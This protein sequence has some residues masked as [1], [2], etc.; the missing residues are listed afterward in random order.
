MTI[1]DSPERAGGR[2]PGTRSTDTVVG[3]PLEEA[4]R[5]KVNLA[6]G[7][8]ARRGDGYHELDSL[9]VFAELADRLTFEPAEHLMLERG[10][11]FGA[12]LAGEPDDLIL[13][14]ARLLAVH[15]GRPAAARITLD[16]RIPVA[17][18]LGGGSADAAATLRGL[19]RL[20]RLDLS[21]AELAPLARE[22]GADVPVCLH[23]R[24]ARMRGIGERLEA[25]VGLPP[26]PL[27]LVNPGKAV[28]T[29]AVFEALGLVA[30]AP[31]RPAL[32]PFEGGDLIDWLRGWGNHLEAP[33]RARVPAIGEVLTILAAAPGCRLARMSGSGA[34]CF[35]VFADAAARDRAARALRRDFPHWWV[36]ATVAGSGP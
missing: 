12:A 20:W 4:A 23:G 13:R 33:A 15:A 25:L 8:L 19:N 24:P 32:P 7:V 18:G 26:L 30:G 17:A 22:L 31:P 36:E 1:P 3:A 11:P 28:P 5:A 14:A 29:G 34:T 35:G 6:L 9:V 16:K 27:L 10:G 2:V 21:P